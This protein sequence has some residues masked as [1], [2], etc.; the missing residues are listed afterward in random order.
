MTIFY[1]V[2]LRGWLVFT[3]DVL[4]AALSFVLS[5]LL[6]FGEIDYYF[7]QAI[8]IQ[9][10][11]LFSALSAIIFIFSGLYRGVW[12]Y[13]SIDDLVAIIRAV[14]LS[15]LFFLLVMFIWTRLDDLPRSI[16]I[17]NWFVLMALLGGPRFMYRFIKDRNTNPKKIPLDNQVLVLLVG[18]G[19]G[20][21]HFI[22]GLQQDSEKNYHVIGIISET[23]HRVG[24]QIRG[25][26]II[27]TT[28]EIPTLLKSLRT[29][30]MRPQR[31][32]LTN[33]DFDGAII[34]ELLDV[35][36]S[37]GMTLAR[38]P[39]LTEFQS[40]ENS[41]DKLRPIAVEDLL[42]RP[43]TPLDKEAMQKL[44][45]GRNILI[46]GA[47][48]SIGAELARQVAAL[49]PHNLIL[50][51]NSEYALYKI[52]QELDIQFSAVPRKMVLADVRVRERLLALLCENKPAVVFHAAALKHV[53]LVEKNICEGVLTNVLGTINIADACHA[54]N[55]NTMILVSTDKAVNPSSI[56]GATKRVAE[57]YCQTL[58]QARSKNDECHFLIVRF[59]N[60]L[61]STGSV[62]P[63]FQNQLDQGGPITVTHADMTRFFMTIREAVELILEA[64][65]KGKEYAG[66]GGTI[67]VLDM[68]KPIKILDLA[69]QM[70]RLSGMTPGKDI[71]IEFT[72]IRPGE[73]LYE[74]VLH[75]AEKTVPTSIPG[76]HLAT[77]RTN[78]IKFF[79]KTLQILIKN[80]HTDNTKG[81]FKALKKIVPEYVS[82][83]D[84]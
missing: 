77:S 12:R 29:Q 16:P 4:M 58:E 50:L 32:I 67:F 59:G 62:V 34:R 60:V 20:A 36:T 28:S 73:K 43:Q 84:Q 48:G 24:Q 51:D 68:G 8:I 64:S 35:A 1:K 78:D 18:A 27:G 41:I 46:T 49:E 79:D 81:V 75:S 57:I 69:K 42:G 26:D 11:F 56:M 45:K 65:A 66:T 9:S 52:D 21:D 13:A 63:L 17:I 53:P 19:H 61:G 25:V 54:A 37:F 31:L 44:I 72:G 7:N 80:A 6:R 30:G 3:H 76:L 33:N 55:V 40:T 74:E 2:P 39:K 47:G 23:Q 83:L 15:I 5:I 82:Q 71:K 14:S 10:T 22:R 38:I 70:I